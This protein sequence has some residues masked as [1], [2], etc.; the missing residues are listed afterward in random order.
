MKRDYIPSPEHLLSMYTNP[1][2]HNRWTVAT[3]VPIE[4]IKIDRSIFSFQND[5]NWDDVDYMVKNFEQSAW[6]PIFVNSDFFL[7]DGQH[8]L[9]TAKEMH[10][11]YIDVVVDRGDRQ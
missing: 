8:R 6:F 11:K 1:Q 9:A 4:E 2:F 7:L 10:L 3:K 5:V